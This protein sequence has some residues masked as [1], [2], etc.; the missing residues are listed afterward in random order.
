MHHAPV[1][2]MSQLLTRWSPV[3]PSGDSPV[4]YFSRGSEQQVDLMHVPKGTCMVLSR[5]S[6]SVPVRSH[7]ALVLMGFVLNVR[8]STWSGGRG[9][10]APA[11]LH[12]AYVAE[13]GLRFRK[14]KLRLAC[15]TRRADAKNEGPGVT[16]GA[17]PKTKMRALF[18][19]SQRVPFAVRC[20]IGGVTKKETS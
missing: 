6:Q 20:R 15:C 17:E 19:P 1:H 18:Q 5:V 12:W 11:A 8:S 7:L 10:L 3:A 14:M 13:R 9:R 16:L 4:L 2:C